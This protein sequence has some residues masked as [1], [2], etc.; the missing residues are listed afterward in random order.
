MSDT[1]KCPLCNTEKPIEKFIDNKLYHKHA[2]CISCCGK[3]SKRLTALTKFDIKLCN[4]LNLDYDLLNSYKGLLFDKQFG[5]DTNRV[6]DEL[7]SEPLDEN[8]Q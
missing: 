1:K 2:V 8:V 5:T 7:E 3:A 6:I 4:N